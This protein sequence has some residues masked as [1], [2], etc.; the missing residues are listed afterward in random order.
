MEDFAQLAVLLGLTG[1]DEALA[2]F[3]PLGAMFFVR[4]SIARNYKITREKTKPVETDKSYTHQCYLSLLK[5]ELAKMVM[6]RE[7]ANR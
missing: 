4:R 7:L 3:F 2:T 5:H 1:S 6:Y